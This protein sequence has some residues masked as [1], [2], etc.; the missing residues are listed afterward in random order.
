MLDQC[1]QIFRHRLAF[2]ILPQTEKIPRRVATFGGMVG[3]GGDKFAALDYS[4][5]EFREL[6][7]ELRIFRKFCKLGVLSPLCRRR[8]LLY[9]VVHN[10]L[11][12][13]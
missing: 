7:P 8:R 6:P 10:H 9:S 1:G 4:G 13:L 12:L 11:R 2:E 3:S 5:L